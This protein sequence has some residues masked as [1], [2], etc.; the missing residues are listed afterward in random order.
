MWMGE[1]RV[2]DGGRGKHAF[3]YMVNI[4]RHRKHY[5][6]FPVCH[7]LSKRL[8]LVSRIVFIKIIYVWLIG[9]I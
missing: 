5:N 4:E 3:V 7:L 2:R 1:N 9:S 6:W 8:G